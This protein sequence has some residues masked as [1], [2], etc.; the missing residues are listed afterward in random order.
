MAERVMVP[1]QRRQRI[2]N[3]VRTGTA[4]VSDLARAFDVSEMTVG[5]DLRALRDAGQLEGVHGGAGDPGPE[6]ARQ[7]GGRPGGAGHTG[8]ERPFVEIALEGA[9]V[10]D[11]IGRAAAELVQDG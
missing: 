3:A 7:P 1:A 10:K 11:R 8:P 2:L 4:H 6:D 9:E 5:R